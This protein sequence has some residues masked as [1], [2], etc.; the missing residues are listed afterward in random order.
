MTRGRLGKS[1]EEC[2]LQLCSAGVVCLAPCSAK[3]VYSLYHCHNSPDLGPVTI[4]FYRCRNGGPERLIACLGSPSPDA[5]E[6]TFESR[7]EQ[8]EAGAEQRA[9]RR[10]VA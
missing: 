3:S 9:G 10:V 4:P 2:E 1:Q 5:A 6:L 7:E 8:A